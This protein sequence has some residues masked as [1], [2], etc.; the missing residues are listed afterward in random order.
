MDS[1]N[2]LIGMITLAYRSSLI[3]RSDFV[4]FEVVTKYTLH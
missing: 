1:V 2:I 4:L 3:D